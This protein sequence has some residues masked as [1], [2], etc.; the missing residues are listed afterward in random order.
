MAFPQ[1]TIV[2]VPREQFS[3]TQVS[4]E[5]IFAH[6]HQPFTL[7]YVDG[8]APDRVRRYLEGQAAEK[9]FR[10]IR[11]DRYL[12]AN[13]A[14][15]LAVPY[16]RTKYVVFIDNDVIVAPNWLEPLIDCA[17]ETGSWLVGPVYCVG[18]LRNPII[19]TLGA[20]HGIDE[21]DGKRRW[22]ERHLFCG[23][24]FNAVRG[25]LHRRPIDLVEF[26][27]LL[28]RTEAFERLGM[29]DA[30]LLSYF[31]HND[32][33]LQVRDA[34]GS[35]YVEP[36]SIV[37]Y[38]PPPPFAAS[39]VPFFL[40]RWSDRWISSS[41]AHFARKNKIDATDPIFAAHYDYQQAQRARL[42]RHPRRTVRRVLGIRA[43]SA[44]EAALDR[45]LDWTVV[46]RG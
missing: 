41:V 43:L 42:L 18:D 31:D 30:A 21:A 46:A 10:L 26:H 32:L 8:N 16:L 25:E 6:T 15:N 17:D 38:V 7:I 23:Q 1:V 9:D 37:T 28:M 13:V 24:P 33:C 40:L 4:L 2:V 39:D 22:R 35:I 36:R 29:F 44:M 45:V 14:R 5:S 12:P 11:E 3:K 34:G 27:C 20:E 19:H